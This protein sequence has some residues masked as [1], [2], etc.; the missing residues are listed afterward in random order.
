MFVE[1]EKD[2]MFGNLQVNW[3]KTKEELHTIICG[4][5]NVLPCLKPSLH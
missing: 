2:K 1:C 4:L 5:Y 3:G